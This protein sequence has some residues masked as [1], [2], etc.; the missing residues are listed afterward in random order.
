MSTTKLTTARAIANAGR[1]KP[2][3]RAVKPAKKT[4]VERT[5]VSVNVPEDLLAEFQRH[6]DEMGLSLSAYFIQG[7]RGLLRAQGDV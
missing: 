7:A 3:V 2:A 1:S 5:R 4:K 6:A